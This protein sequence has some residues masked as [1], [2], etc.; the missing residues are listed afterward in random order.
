MSTRSIILTIGNQNYSNEL[1][2]IRHYKHSDGYPS[3][4][5][6][7]LIETLES[8]EKEVKEY[9]DHWKNFKS[10][11]P[12]VISNDFFSGRLIGFGSSVYGQGVNVDAYEDDKA[13]YDGK[14]EYKHLGYQE[15]LEWIYILDLNNKTLNIYGG[16]YSG[17]GPDVAVKKGFVNP[18]K[19]IKKLKDDYQNKELELTKECVA[20]V[21]G[22]GFKINK[23]KNKFSKGVKS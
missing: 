18:E 9:N 23:I 5:L 1:S 21:E 20:K 15:D 11:T 13:T 22:L 10:S 16:S 3:G 8:C 17:Q 14:L 12:K 6:P 2:I 19:Y 7:L 4:V